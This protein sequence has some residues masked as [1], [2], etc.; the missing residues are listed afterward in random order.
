MKK[1]NWSTEQEKAIK[2][3]LG[4][5]L[6]SASAGSGKTAVLTER[7]FQIIK[8]G[9]KLNEILVLTFTNNAAQ[10]MRDRIR[11][12]LLT[13]GL[14]KLA[15]S[16]DAVNIQTYDAFALSIVKKYRNFIDVPSSIK[17]IDNSIMELELNRQLS[18]LLKEKYLSEEKDV[19]DLIYRYCLK[20]DNL[21]KN[22]ILDIYHKASSKVDSEAYLSSLLSEYFDESFIHKNIQSIADSFNK[23]LTNALTVIKGISSS[24]FADLYLDFF[25]PY[26]HL[27]SFDDI[28][29]AINNEEN[30][31]K[32]FP[33]MLAKYGLDEAEKVSINE[34]K[35][36]FN[37]FR[38]NYFN[39]K[40]EQEIVNHMLSTKGFA[41]TLVNL[42]KEL[43]SRM[44]SFKHKFNSYTFS[45]IFK[46]ANK[47]VKIPEVH[48]KFHSQ[49][50]YIMIDEYQDTSDV[51]EDFINSFANN[52]VYVVGDVKQS[53]YGFRNAN[54]DIFL[55]KFND[56]RKG[57][58]GTLYDLPANYRS[59]GE[60]ISYVNALF[61]NVMTK[62][63]TALDYAN[64]HHM[65]YGS[66]DYENAKG[67][68]KYD[69]EALVYE[70]DKYKNMLKDEME[71]RCVALDI[72]KRCNEH[73][74]VANKDKN[75]IRDINYGDFAILSF[76]KRSFELYQRIFNEYNIPLYPTFDKVLKDR[77]LS[78]V[79]ES[80]IKAISLYQQND[81]GKK[82]AWA[83]CSIL[84]SF[85]FNINDEE[86]DKIFRTSNFTE[87]P[88]FD[89][90]R[91]LSK[92][93]EELSLSNLT[94]EV[95]K[96]FNFYDKIITLGDISENTELMNNLYSIASQME[97]M[98]YTI[99]DFVSYFED[100]DEY[101]IEP[102]YSGSKS[103]IDSVKLMS[104]HASK[105]L[106]FKY[107][108]YVGL[109]KKFN[110][111][112]DKSAIM[113]TNEFGLLLPNQTQRIYDNI[114]KRIAKKR[115]KAELYKEQLRVFYVA[116]TRA[117]EKI[118]LVYPLSEKNPGSFEK[119]NSYFKFISYGEVKIDETVIDLNEKPILGDSINS[120]R[121]IDINL[122]LPYKFS[123]E[124]HEVRRISKEKSE[125]ADVKAL[126]IGTKFHYYLELVNFATKDTSFI[127][128][129]HDRKV[130]DK[131]LSNS[132]FDNAS[133]A[134]V[135]HEY[136]FYD[137]KNDV[138]GVID[139]LLIYDDHIDIVDFKLSH[140]D[141][142]A[143]MRQV[144]MYKDYIEQIAEG[145][146][147]STYIMGIL[148]GNILKAN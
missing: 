128:N 130:I 16:I 84:R 68:N 146:S 132:L 97:E 78:L 73:E 51:Q 67:E 143:Y 12:K 49:Y 82:F 25:A 33:K 140:V 113:L 70:K 65:N 54:C 142:E 7:V 74:K 79:F 129:E 116:L 136:S 148:S 39:F 37:D 47:I 21:I 30:R 92:K 134:K 36:T 115:A 105:G 121:D 53:I 89:I 133:K 46:M 50:K 76:S 109:T 57:N 42:A 87:Y 20:D 5:A 63:N 139:L 23:F 104:I 127:K 106:Q 137:E 80:I 126:E 6:V 28:S 91:T 18:N 8:K 55:Q 32:N 108:Y 99:D 3:D 58:G 111:S 125:D 19:K 110:Y 141:D 86:I 75:A 93:S 1:M 64:E 144:G 66:K 81:Y 69:A 147:V 44:E 35:E 119:C 98:N 56:Y 102:A 62:E 61:S 11:D 27:T 24:E 94:L 107:V 100:L 145:R 95:Y 72:I 2:H 22:T 52:N 85:L 41:T 26:D 48:D 112:E 123:Q 34:I 88:L 138:S 103:S 9:T 96:E 83:Y 101:E 40:S 4:N 131:F 31:S 117:E 13:D 71:A 38:S 77:D 59:R 122:H 118:I 29:Q 14:D 17:I 60:V 124:V 114:F 43:Y 90:L 135:A 120:D 15:S 10:E 45:D